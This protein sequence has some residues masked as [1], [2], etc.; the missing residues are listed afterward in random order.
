MNS[1]GDT[2]E[3]FEYKGPGICLEPIVLKCL[4]AQEIWII[5]R[6]VDSRNRTACHIVSSTH[7]GLLA[8]TDEPI[9]LH[10]NYRDP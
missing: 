8:E 5:G 2:Q 10:T 1:E 9:S 3:R 4:Y 6:C 7:T